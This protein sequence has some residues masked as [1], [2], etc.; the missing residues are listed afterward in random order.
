M[1]KNNVDDVKLL[2]RVEELER[3]VKNLKS[4]FDR[5]KI[6]DSSNY[7][8]IKISEELLN[9]NNRLLALIEKKQ[10]LI[11]KQKEIISEQNNLIQKQN[12]LLKNACVKKINN[13]VVYDVKSYDEIP[14]IDLLKLIFGLE[15]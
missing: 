10:R 8:S 2:K 4:K 15:E 11:E 3:A 6:C 9:E 14:K 5:V 12:E 7:D 13:S 1:D